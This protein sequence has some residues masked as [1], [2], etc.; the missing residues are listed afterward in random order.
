MHDELSLNP[1]VQMNAVCRTWFRLTDLVIDQRALSLTLEVLLAINQP[2]ALSLFFSLRGKHG[3]H[4]LG[5]LRGILFVTFWLVDAVQV[6]LSPAPSIDS[7]SLG[8]VLQYIRNYV[9]HFQQID[10]M[11]NVLRFELYVCTPSCW[12]YKD[13]WDSAHL[14]RGRV[15]LHWCCGKLCA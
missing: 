14:R 7:L 10:V 11:L 13:I 8:R 4:S 6:I 15:P 2:F 1:L 9:C 3:G 12:I 5:F